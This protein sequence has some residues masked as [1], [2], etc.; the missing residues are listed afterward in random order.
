[1][2]LRLLSVTQR[3][4]ESPTRRH[5]PGIRLQSLP[6]SRPT[7]GQATV[8]VRIRLHRHSIALHLVSSFPFTQWQIHHHL[9]GHAR[10]VHPSSRKDDA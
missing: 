3:T 4:T 6:T 8:L 7:R 10:P 5:P 2:L 1:M 9:G